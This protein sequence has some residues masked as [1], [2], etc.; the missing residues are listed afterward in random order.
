[1]LQVRTP[2]TLGPLFHSFKILLNSVLKMDSGFAHF[3]IVAFSMSSKIRAA[4]K[5]AD[6]ASLPLPVC[7]FIFYFYKT[8]L[9]DEKSLKLVFCYQIVPSDSPWKPLMDFVLVVWEKNETLTFDFAN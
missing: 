4:F 7:G 5:P 9:K 6:I 3:R 8:G 1:M 2:V